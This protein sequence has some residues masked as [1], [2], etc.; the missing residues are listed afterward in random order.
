MAGYADRSDCG[1][2]MRV[3]ELPAAAAKDRRRRGG[4]LCATIGVES[5]RTAGMIEWKPR[6]YFRLVSG[7]VK[8]GKKRF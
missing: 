1:L 8:I 4:V 5:G 7:G 6:P 2:A 3:S